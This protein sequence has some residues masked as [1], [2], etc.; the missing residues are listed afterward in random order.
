MAYMK[1]AF[2]VVAVLLTLPSFVLARVII[3]E[4]AWMGTA[5]SANN[6]WM[7]LHNDGTSSIALD[8]WKLESVSGGPSIVLA[9]SVSACGF[10]L[11]ERTDDTSVPNISADAIYTGALSNAGEHLVLRDAASTTVD[12]IQ[13]SSGWP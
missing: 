7:E 13:A 2:L 8:G 1:R 5:I 4:V 3:N 12:E 6:E 10:F 11:L 9:G